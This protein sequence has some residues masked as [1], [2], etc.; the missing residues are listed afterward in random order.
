[1]LVRPVQNFKAT[2]QLIAMGPV[3][4]RILDK[5]TGPGGGI[6]F[7]RTQQLNCVTIFIT[8]QYKLVSQQR[9]SIVKLNT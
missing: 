4:L 1:M 5:S 6:Q 2:N 8:V 3:Q 9:I 7:V